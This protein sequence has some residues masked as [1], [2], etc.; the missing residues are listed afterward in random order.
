MLPVGGRVSF[1][2]SAPP[3]LRHQV[4]AAETEWS[5]RAGLLYRCSTLYGEG[6]WDFSHSTS[7]RLHNF[8]YYFYPVL[9]RN[10]HLFGAFKAP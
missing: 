3:L 1:C 8:Y 10:A 7:L 9:V 5:A 6:G 4:R 2:P